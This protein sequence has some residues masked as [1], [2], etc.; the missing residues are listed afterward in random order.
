[1]GTVVT[2]VV[3]EISAGVLRRGVA[4]ASSIAALKVV[5]DTPGLLAVVRSKLGSARLPSDVGTGGKELA[6]LGDAVAIEIL[7]MVVLTC[8]NC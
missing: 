7:P 1:M 3:D 2:E 8:I 4:P 5:M 6:A